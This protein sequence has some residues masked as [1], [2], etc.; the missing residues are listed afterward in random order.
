MRRRHLVWSDRLVLTGSIP[1]SRRILVVRTPAAGGG[2]RSH[3]GQQEKV[4]FIIGSLVY[5]PRNN[6]KKHT[7]IIPVNFL[8][9]PQPWMRRPALGN[10]DC[11]VGLII[12]CKLQTLAVGCCCWLMEFPGTSIADS[13]LVSH[14]AAGQQPQAVMPVISLVLLGLSYFSR[15]ASRRLA[16]VTSVTVVTDYSV[17]GN[18]AEHI[19]GA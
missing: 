10:A 16:F 9:S 7:I 3:G 2:Q 13:A 18:P 15:P 4:F 5:F 1:G 19:S 11:A 6:C 17:G 8:I 14:L 12:H